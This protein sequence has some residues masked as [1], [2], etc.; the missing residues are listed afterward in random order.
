[1][2]RY[3]SRAPKKPKRS[4]VII[5]LNVLIGIL[6]AAVIITAVGYWSGNRNS[7]YDRKF[8]DSTTHYNV[9]RGEYSELV[10]DYNYDGG[11][12]GMVNKGYEDLAA[13]AEY[14]DAAFR[15]S[16]Y[17]KAGDAEVSKVQRERMEKAASEAGIY[18]PEMSKID[19]LLHR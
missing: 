6:T 16:A 12:I 14:A 11:S 2:A 5:F 17:E 9:E 1:M 7:Y 13:V 18:S 10:Y 8:G 19:S 15:H 3:I 4:K